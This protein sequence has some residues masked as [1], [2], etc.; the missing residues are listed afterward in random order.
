MI[1]WVYAIQSDGLACNSSWH[2]LLM[3]RQA[4]PCALAVGCRFPARGDRCDPAWRTC[5]HHG[6]PRARRDTRPTRRSVSES[7]SV[8]CV[9]SLCQSVGS[10]SCAVLRGW[11]DGCSATG[12]S[13]S[14]PCCGVVRQQAVVCPPSCCVVFRVKGRVPDSSA[15]RPPAVAHCPR[16][17]SASERAA[18]SRGAGGWWTQLWGASGCEV[19]VL[20]LELVGGSTQGQHPA[21]V[22]PRGRTHGRWQHPGAAPM[23]GGAR[24]EQARRAGGHGSLCQHRDCPNSDCP[25][26]VTP[27][28]TRAH[29]L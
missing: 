17:E 11:D 28:V 10:G 1:D 15:T 2:A 9:C 29:S 20:Y 25:N 6:S 18:A 12:G 4:Q 8:V 7:R 16:R 14:L 13:A 3:C 24:S 26:T 27:T 22:T 21:G 23:A 19:R 5:S